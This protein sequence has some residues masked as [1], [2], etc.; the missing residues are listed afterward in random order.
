MTNLGARSREVSY[1]FTTSFV[2]FGLGRF[3]YYAVAMVV[4][5]AGAG[6]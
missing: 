1:I 4:A 2:A 6:G 5:S 3:V